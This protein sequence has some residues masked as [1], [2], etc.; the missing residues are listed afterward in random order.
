MIDWTSHHLEP[1]WMLHPLGW[2]SCADGSCEGRDLPL[3]ARRTE[4]GRS[5]VHRTTTRSLAQS[6]TPPGLSQAFL[7]C[8]RLRCCSKGRHSL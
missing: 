2:G 8:T 4:Q 3:A 6:N 7:S 5:G 1:Y